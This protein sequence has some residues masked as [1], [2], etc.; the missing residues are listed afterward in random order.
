MDATTSRGPV[1]SLPEELVLSVLQ[2]HSVCNTAKG[3]AAEQGIE[4]YCTL[5]DIVQ[6]CG[7]GM[8]LPPKELRKKMYDESWL[9]RITNAM[10]RRMERREVEGIRQ[11]LSPEVFEK[12]C[13]KEDIEQ[14]TALG[15]ELADVLN[16]VANHFISKRIGPLPISL[17]F[18]ELVPKI[19]ENE[20]FTIST[21][22]LW[23]FYAAAIL[24]QKGRL[25][26]AMAES[27]CLAAAYMGKGTPLTKLLPGLE[28]VEEIYM[29][30]SMVERA[31]HWYQASR[32]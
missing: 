15:K 14:I 17:L 4:D 19:D 18:S 22:F 6:E 28:R 13:D 12:H 3:A 31:N 23:W 9:N 2:N 27:V 10:M 32:S 20:G 26:E 8:R 16:R 5:C 21:I 1:P 25:H 7:R 11:G 24:G 30:R 29:M